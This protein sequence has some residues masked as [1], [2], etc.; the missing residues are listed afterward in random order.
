MSSPA[1]RP[2]RR[3]DRSD[4]GVLQVP[5]S[6]VGAVGTFGH[7]GTGRPHHGATSPCCL[8]TTRKSRLSMPFY[9][10]AQPMPGRCVPVNLAWQSTLRSIK[11][12][13]R[14]TSWE[15]ALLLH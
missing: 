1:V 12:E 2:L 7:N 6:V 11:V 10:I 9:M 4:G 14:R 8:Q 15:Y 3:Y 5:A 13:I